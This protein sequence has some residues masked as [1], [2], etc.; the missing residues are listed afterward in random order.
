M[1]RLGIMILL[2]RGV[3]LDSD[4]TAASF[5]AF[6]SAEVSADRL[7]RARMLRSSLTIL[8]LSMVPTTSE[9]FCDILRHVHHLTSLT[10]HEADA[11]FDSIPDAAKLFAKMRSL[12]HLEVAAS[13]PTS[14]LLTTF[15]SM[16][17]Q[18]SSAAL[19]FALPDEE[20]I[21][22]YTTIDP[23][24]VLA[25][26][27][28]T[29][30]TIR[31]SG[32]RPKA[33]RGPP[34]VFPRVNHLSLDSIVNPVTVD[35]FKAYPNLRSLDIDAVRDDLGTLDA[36]QAE[37]MRVKNYLA[38]LQLGTWRALERVS[39]PAIDV[40]ALGLACEVT[41]L[42]L[43][44]DPSQHDQLLVNVLQ[45][46][47]GVEHLVLTTSKDFFELGWPV[48]G[49]ELIMLAE[50][51]DNFAE[52]TNSYVHRCLNK[53]FRVHTDILEGTTTRECSLKNVT[54]V[55]QVPCHLFRCHHPPPYATD[56]D[57]EELECPVK[58]ALASYDLSL[59]AADFSDAVPSLRTVSIDITHNC[60]VVASHSLDTTAQPDQECY[61][62]ADVSDD[63]SSS[64]GSEGSCESASTTQTRRSDTTTTEPDRAS[65][66]R[67]IPAHNRGHAN[68]FSSYSF[69]RHK[70]T[71]AEDE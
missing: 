20:G 2:D 17:S 71:A 44:M 63:N 48:Q 5:A 14:N 11:L 13:R 42:A 55:L 56:D 50:Q 35:L 36:R 64:S 3:V 51:D 27:C 18:L 66:R 47:Q 46:T 61:V 30:T 45:R 26:A 15:K 62:P 54:M 39:G 21:Q 16:Q 65:P 28:S 25:C 7:P 49:S 23:F 9:T 41:T 1:Y 22:A 24:R 6:L 60:D 57:D 8:P 69:N 59:A 40:L 70:Y 37:N 68:G 38:Q 33:S 58:D 29:L 67:R 31:L 43:S 32:V 52:V 10:I 53:V 34:M 4:H 19:S 12:K